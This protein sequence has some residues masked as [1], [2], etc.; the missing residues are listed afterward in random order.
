MRITREMLLKLAQ[1]TVTQRVRSDRS[2]MGV[3]LHGSSLES[4]PLLGGTT[5]ID[6]FFVHDGEIGMKREIVRITDDVHLDISHYSRTEFRQTRELRLHPWLGPILYNCKIIH[7]PQHF[8]DFVQATVRGQFDRPDYVLGRARPQAEQARHIWLSFTLSPPTPGLQAI[9]LYLRAVEHAADAIA[10]LS[11]VPLTERRFLLKFPE[12]A[13][14]VDRPGLY[15]GLLG[16]LGGPTVDAG[17]LRSWLPG[18]RTAYEIAPKDA[19]SPRL[20]PAR[21]PY[22]L[23][24]YEA[25]IEGD[26]PQAVLWPLLRT[27]VQLISVLPPGSP[28]QSAWSDAFTHLGLLGEAF[29]ERLAALDAYLDMVEETLE[30]WARENGA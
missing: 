19:V 20:A 28:S 30:I 12:K 27:W 3:Y 24:A 15:P 14:A 1:D 10:L 11:G 5:D 26:R 9:A 7:D 21:F 23:R 22:Y 18:W 2:V 8:I 25:I 16:L 6:L 4:E 29:S 13:K 17:I